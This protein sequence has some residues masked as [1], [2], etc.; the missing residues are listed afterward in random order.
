MSKQPS[1]KASGATGIDKEYDQWLEGGGYNMMELLLNA[2]YWFD[3][4][5]QNLIDEKGWPP[6]TRSQSVI[7]VHLSQ[8][9]NRTVDIAKHMG[10]SKQAINRSVNELVAIGLLKLS[11]DPTDK[12]AK[13]VTPSAKGKQIAEYALKALVRIEKEINTRVGANAGN[14]LRSLL[15]RDWGEPL[16][17]Y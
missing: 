10:V 16:D 13:I 7:F 2:Y 9:R 1:K 11:T 14:E 8:G 15:S 12:R 3:E 17:K 4:S 5:L 6:V